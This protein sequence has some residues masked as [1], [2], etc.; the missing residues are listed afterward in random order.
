MTRTTDQ[1]P[2]DQLTPSQAAYKFNDLVQ[3][4]QKFQ[5][6]DFVSAW[7]ATRI[8]YPVV[9]RKMQEGIK[10][11]GGANGTVSAYDAYGK[12]VSDP[13]PFGQTQQTPVTPLSPDALKALGLNP[14]DPRTTFDV[15]N[16][17][18]RANGYKLAPLNKTSVADAVSG[19]LCGGRNAAMEAYPD[20]FSN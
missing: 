6:L 12:Q 17:A 11:G 2:D 18:F 4:A 16:A 15:A 19:V 8:G 13:V 9:F 3:Q 20:L 1:T 10:P 7:A 14:N 5:S